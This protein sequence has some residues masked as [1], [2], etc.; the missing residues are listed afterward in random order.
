M[1]TTLLLID[2]QNDYF[3]GGAFPLVG[4]EDA[5]RNARVLLDAFRAAGLP[6]VHLQ[7]GETDP[8][9]TFLRAGTP[10]ADLHPLVA[11]AEGET[12]LP[13][14]HPNGFLE[15]ELAAVLEA[16]GTERLVV[17]G[18]MSSMC[19]DATTR[20]ALD[21]DVPVILAHDACAAPDLTFGGTAVAGASVHAAFMTALGG[22][23]ATLVSSSE[24]AAQID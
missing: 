4:P 14:R 12:V 15:T 19:V 18:M 2:I 5:A 6:V 16:A 11:A 21:R 3:P 1:T 23:G 17:A 9:A 7:H 13:K 10:G 24:L 20:A 22:A 8:G